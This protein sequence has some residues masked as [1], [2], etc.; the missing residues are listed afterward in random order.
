MKNVFFKNYL[1]NCPYFYYNFYKTLKELYYSKTTIK[2]S[3]FY[4]ILKSLNN[5]NITIKIVM[6]LLY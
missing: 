3:Y 6:P 4:K 1:V 2:W 5:T